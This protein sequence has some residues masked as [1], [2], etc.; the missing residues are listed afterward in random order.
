MR[1]EWGVATRSPA[2][3]AAAPRRKAKGDSC[4]LAWRT[5]TSCFKRVVAWA[6]STA[7]GSLSYAAGG[8]QE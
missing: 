5:G 1:P 2:M 7:M 3:M 4:I 6:L 8:S